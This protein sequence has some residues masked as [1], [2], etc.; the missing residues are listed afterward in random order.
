MISPL[1]GPYNPKLL[2]GVPV[3]VDLQKRHK[4][5]EVEPIEVDRHACESDPSHS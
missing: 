2:F 3:W 5:A 1:K 4:G